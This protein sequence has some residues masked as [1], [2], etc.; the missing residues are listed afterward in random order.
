MI[1]EITFR[2]IS[3]VKRL[4]DASNPTEPR[5]TRVRRVLA[6]S[7]D[8]IT[9]KVK[10]PR[11]DGLTLSAYGVWLTDRDEDAT[12]RFCVKG[13]YGFAYA[14]VLRRRTS[15]YVL[16]DVG[17]NIGL[18]SLVAARFSRASRVV[19]F[20]PDPTSAALLRANARVNGVDVEI[21]EAAVSSTS[22]TATLYVPVG[23]SGAAS[24][25]RQREDVT[26][27]EVRKLSGSDLD[28]VLRAS[29]GETE[30]LVKLD[31]E[32]H[33]HEALQ[34]LSQWI[35]WRDVRSVWVE[36]S[37]ATDVEACIELLERA[38]FERVFSVGTRKH[39]DVLFERGRP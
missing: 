37:R 18:Y 11:R 22:G 1:H 7:I 29:S 28:E 25:R 38:G 6:R 35:G 12:F 32:G 2:C 23:H 30:V 5:R 13:S 24:L 3:T 9:H 31:V 16:L 21:I 17:A 10:P 20:E 8:A 4:L 36:F 14:N 33:E 15:P 27:V 34:A 26:P 19:A 39:E